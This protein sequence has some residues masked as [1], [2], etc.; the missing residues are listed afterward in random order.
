LRVAR[1]FINQ[2]LSSQ[3]FGTASAYSSGGVKSNTNGNLLGIKS[4]A[5]NASSDELSPQVSERSASGG[6]GS[7]QGREST[8]TRST[9]S[10]GL[11]TPGVNVLSSINLNGNGQEKKDNALPGVFPAT[12]MI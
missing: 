11:R 1:A 6:S 10:N 2:D 3:G 4:N 8:S 7:H 12:Q 9:D 5:T